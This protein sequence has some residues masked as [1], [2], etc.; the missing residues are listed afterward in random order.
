MGTREHAADADF[1]AAAAIDTAVAAALDNVV[2]AAAV[3]AAAAVSMK[4]CHLML[5]PFVW[6]TP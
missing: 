2:A 6:Q 4:G 1:A 3:A 5:L